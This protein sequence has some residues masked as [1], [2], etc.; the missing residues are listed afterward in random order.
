[1]LSEGVGK[2]RRGARGDHNSR[3]HGFT[4]SRVHGFTGSRGSEV[5]GRN[6]GTRARTWE[7]EPVNLGTC[8]PVNPSYEPVNPSLV[9]VWFVDFA[10]NRP[11]AWGLSGLGKSSQ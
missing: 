2:R 10:S 7:L 5:R 9:R 4:G 11:V 6:L 1:F 3:V 8:E